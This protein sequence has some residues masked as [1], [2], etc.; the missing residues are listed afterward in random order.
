MTKRPGYLLID[1]NRFTP[2]RKLRHECIIGG[3]GIYASIAAASILA[4]THR[5][6]YMRKLHREFPH[7]NWKS[8]K[9][10]GTEEHRNAIEAHG[11]CPY[12]RKSFNIVPSQMRLFSDDEI[13][14]AVLADV[15]QDAPGES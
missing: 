5:D 7:Y 10:Y 6:Q 9:G 15:A 1:G 8:N 3:D 12:H 2:Y 13:P 11:L 14:E 4:K